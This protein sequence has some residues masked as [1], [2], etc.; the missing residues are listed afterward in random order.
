MG[1][2]GYPEE[3][4]QGRK[5]PTARFHHHAEKDPDDGQGEHLEQCVGA[6]VGAPLQVSRV[7]TCADRGEQ[8]EPGA[9]G[10]L[11]TQDVDQLD[12][13]RAGRRTDK[14]EYGEMIKVAE[15]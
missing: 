1:E 11:P 10:Q 7:E 2:G 8:A 14:A 9:A 3:G 5:Q 12:R 13:G 4:H 6:D 15:S